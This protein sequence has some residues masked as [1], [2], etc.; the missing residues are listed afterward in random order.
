MDRLVGVEEGRS[1]TLLGAVVRRVQ[2]LASHDAE[3]SVAGTLMG[4]RV[5]V[6]V[7]ARGLLLVRVS[8]SLARLTVRVL[9]IAA[10]V[11]VSL[12]LVAVALV[13]RVLV[14]LVTLRRK[15]L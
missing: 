6:R 15:R 10:L 11:L 14:G 13:L 4:S 9:L 8:T 2:P 3:L 12:V 7:A 5:L 1:L